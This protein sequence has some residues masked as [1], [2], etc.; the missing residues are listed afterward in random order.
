MDR[1]NYRFRNRWPEAA[2]NAKLSQPLQPPKIQLLHLFKQ[3]PNNGT[4]FSLSTPFGRDKG[5]E[6]RALAKGWGWK[7][8][9]YFLRVIKPRQITNTKRGWDG[10]SL[11][12]RN[13]QPALRR[14]PTAPEYYY[15]KRLGHGRIRTWKSWRRGPPRLVCDSRPRRSFARPP[16]CSRP[17]RWWPS[18]TERPSGWLLLRTPPKVM[19]PSAWRPGWK[20]FL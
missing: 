14:L 15:V 8:C 6:K 9:A 4:T 18:R 19:W 2:T 20:A 13:S 16:R 5:Q 7:S 3:Q 1:K 12:F 17:C 10:K 11:P